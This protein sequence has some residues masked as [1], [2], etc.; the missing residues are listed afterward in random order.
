MVKR[1]AIP[2]DQLQIEIQARSTSAA[3]S[4]D[5]L[6]TSLGKLRTA[7]KGGAG[8][9]TTTKQL[10]AFSQAVQSMQAPTQKIAALVA[11]LKPLETIGKSNLGSALNQ[12][13]KIPDITAG[14]DDAKLSAFAAKIVQVTD[15]V[16]PLAVEMEKVSAG[17][18]RLPANI[19]KAINANARLTKSNK[20]TAFSFNMMAAKFGIIF[21][22]VR[23]VA[24]VIGGWIKES[25]DYVENLN[26]FHV[27]MGEYAAEAKKYAETVGDALGIDP[28]EF[29]RYQAIFQNMTTG[30]GV[31][32]DKALI[33][34]RNL[35]QLGYD[36]ASVFNTDF[37]TAMEK[38]ESAIAGQP[39]PMREWGF[40][41]SE[42]TLKAVALEKGIKKNVETMGQMEKA[43]LRYV[44][45]IETAQRLNLTGDMARTLQA[46]ANQLRVLKSQLTQAA[47]ALGNVFIPALNAFLPYGIAFLKVVRTI[48]NEIANLFGFAL[49]E[50][51]YSGITTG[52]GDVEDVFNDAD[53]AAKKLKNTVLGFD[54]LNILNPNANT[55][56]ETGLGSDLGIT[57]PEYDFLGDLVENKSNDLAEKMEKPFREAL[58]LATTI[59]ITMLAWKIGKSVVD[60]LSW[61]KINAK[62]GKIALSVTLAIA[63]ITI[64]FDNIKSILAGEYK[65]GGLESVIKEAISG[66][67]IGGSIAAMAGGPIGWGIAIGMALVIKITEIIVN[68]DYVKKEL[69]YLWETV[70]S[71]FSGDQAGMF[72]NFAKAAFNAFSA[73]TW[74]NT[75]IKK[76]F[77]D[78]LFE[79]M[80][81]VM[82]EKGG[83]ILER[84]FITLPRDSF[85][86]WLE[87]LGADFHKFIQSSII[88]PATKART[89]IQSAWND[90]SEWFN[91]I[92]TQPIG[93]FFNSLGTSI[94]RAFAGA[95]ENIKKLWSAVVGWFDANI[96]QPLKNMFNKLEFKIKLPHFE[97]TT[98]PAPDWI[99]N[100]LSA[101]GLPTALPKLN[102]SWYANGG[103]PTPGELFFANENGV[104]EFVGSMGNKTAVANNDQ[105]V[106]GVAS[107][108]ASANAEQNALLREQNKLL[109]QLIEQDKTIIFPTSAE[110]G[111]AVSRS[112]GMYDK[113]RGVV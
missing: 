25:N 52:A 29:M 62:G 55:A 51:D 95:W 67:M 36:L 61:M 60:F 80:L 5:A 7:V 27:A 104:P 88:N 48:A 9:T 98:T 14:L 44:Q 97:W 83:S 53:E 108:V 56:I 54:E 20:S 46:P 74:A 100:I 66:G 87:K 16:R 32:S 68:W 30:F 37:N 103:F 59:G 85:N 19:Q 6:S 18:S 28:S 86:G 38:L 84:F 34:S 64:A 39:R 49:P 11:A 91:S 65:A 72:D 50:V 15:A 76:M 45:L 89:S 106:E 101:I 113:A 109:R 43:Q 42:A 40:D 77:G 3:S 75:L 69:S 24:S 26:L 79:K 81:N 111:R 94:S 23:R 31:A 78:E 82:N 22:A 93:G 112:I 70:K 96:I 58:S 41:L 1:M 107:G 47:R 33:M 63:G 110:A 99:A 102:I 21:M 92:V 12:L 4:I 73:D 17:F 8:L 10:Q 90:V 35:T 13:K 57:L 71:A 2:I 105:I